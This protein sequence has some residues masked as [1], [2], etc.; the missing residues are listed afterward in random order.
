MARCALEYRHGVWSDL[1]DTVIAGDLTAALAYVTPAGGAVVTPVA[2]IGLRDRQAGTVAFTTSLGFGR[3]LDRIKQNP[4]VALAYHAREHGFASDPRFVLVQGTARYDAAPDRRVLEEQ[5]QPAST[6]FLGAPRRGP[7]WDRWLSA[8]YG[9]RV[10]VTV[11]VERVISWPDPSCTGEAEIT[12]RPFD[13]RPPDPQSPPENGPAPRV[14]VAHAAR[15]LSK[16]PH[17]L[18]AYVG[19]DG[20]PLIIP[21][22]IGDT[23]PSGIALEGPLPAGGRRAGLLGHRYEPQLIGLEARQHTGWLLDGVYAP[24]TESGFRAPANKTLLLLANGFMA[25]R[26]LKKARALGR[27]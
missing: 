25:R 14:E 21:V 2:P 12:G 15:R 20:F 11:D 1:D 8:Y 16:L 4:R 6:R 5:V 7:F 22:S 24:H 3:K 17:V 18:I 23:D 9:D 10:L 19:A 13:E 27:S 26:G